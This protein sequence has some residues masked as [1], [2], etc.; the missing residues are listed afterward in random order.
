VK[1]DSSIR[2]I[3]IPDP[4]LYL[5]RLHRQY[6]TPNRLNLLFA[7]RCGNPHGQTRVREILHRVK[8]SLDIRGGAFHAFRHG[9]GTILAHAGGEGLKV[10]QDNLGHF[11]LA[12]TSKYI[13][14]V[15]ES[16]RKAVT[17]AADVIYNSSRRVGNERVSRPTRVNLLPWRGKRIKK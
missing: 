5:L 10:V 17:R 12:M 8:K 14:G 4:L 15:P 6:W 9:H 7:N 11:D 2:A 16:R 3:P 1:T 13:H